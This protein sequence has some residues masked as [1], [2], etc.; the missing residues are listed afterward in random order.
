MPRLPFL[1]H[2]RDAG[3]VVIGAPGVALKGPF[4]SRWDRPTTP[5]RARRPFR[6]AATKAMARI[7]PILE[8]AKA[9]G[10]SDLHLS[11]GSPPLLRVHGEVIP[12]AAAPLT[13][14]TSE[15]LMFEL[16]DAA[17]RARFEAS[18]DVD[19]SYEVPD[20]VRV[21]CNVYEQKRGIS[22]AFRMLPSGIPTFE[23]LGLPAAVQRLTELRRGLVLVTGPPGTGKSCTLAAMIDHVN[24]NFRKHVLTIEDPIEH[25]H[26]NVQSLVTQ[27]EV[28]RHTPSFSQAL[29]AALR[30]DPDVILVGELRDPETMA[31]ALTAAATGQ[32]VFGT[33]HTMS[34]PQTV[35]RILDTFEGERQQ[36]V[37][38][39]LADSLRGVLAQR[40]LKRADGR[41]RALAIEILT[42]T[43]AMS[44]LIRER[45]T[46]QLPTVIQ[47]GR[48]DGMQTMDDSV[49]ALM[50]D[51]V[52]TAEEAGNH[53]SSRDAMQ[54]QRPG[55]AEAA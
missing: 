23:S 6:R 47:T 24:R 25:A 2:P 38:L 54:G 7:D 40:L 14:E 31:L 18:R 3:G 32:L 4:S 52:V 21:R 46:F 36:Q 39:M 19:F 34:A 44:T 20:V 41:G 5:G 17:T 13:P 45:K 22:G 8:I 15:Q 50:K 48:K 37:R 9:Q 33:L 49:M 26:V 29:R 11:A 42:S 10:A 30:E 55:R 27:R 53:L 12:I 51:G 16:M 1:C 43:S 28:G 35:D